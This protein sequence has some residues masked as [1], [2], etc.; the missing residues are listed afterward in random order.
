M[1]KW[2][3]AGITAACTTVSFSQQ[4][5]IDFEELSLN[6]SEA[7]YNGSDSSGGFNTQ[8]VF[9]ENIFN[10]Y[11][12][13][14]FSYSNVTDNTTPGYMNQYSSIVGSGDQSEK[15]ALYYGSSGQIQFGQ[16][17]LLDSVKL[18]NTTYAA[19]SMKDG[20]SF[21]KKFGST[22][23]AAGEDD[24]TNGEDY[25][26]VRIF[27]LNAQSEMIDSMDFYLA[28]FRFADS[29]QD[30]ILIDWTNV[31]LSSFPPVQGL[32]FKLFSSDVG[33][34]GMNT[35]AY[36][37]L[38]NLVFHTTLSV[39]ELVQ[40]V[41]VVY[42]NPVQDQLRVIGIETGTFSIVDMTGKQLGN[43]KL[44]SSGISVEKLLPGSYLIEIQSGN[45][46]YKQR[47]LKR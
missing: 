23:N 32:S 29:L 4:T 35:P 30:Y 19:L 10:G 3:L 43:G 41:L 17:V 25:F 38:D 24:G 14:G 12:S 45:K 16:N 31:D 2:V 27:G 46:I 22:K 34:F 42:P 1:K 47:F 11:W 28:D 15:Y 7:Y 37:A 13:G 20:D 26:F 36:F 33:G 8:S 5:T 9:F 6:G 39:N 40:D 21:A 18:T 44:S